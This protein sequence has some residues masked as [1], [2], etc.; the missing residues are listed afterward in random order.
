MVHRKWWGFFGEFWL[1]SNFLVEK[2]LVKGFFSK[3]QKFWNGG[4]FLNR[5]KCGISKGNFGS[6]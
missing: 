1:K 4:F 6:I 3:I 2:I 5:Q